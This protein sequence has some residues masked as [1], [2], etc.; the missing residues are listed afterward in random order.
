M[1]RFG[2][3]DPPYYAQSTATDTSFVVAPGSD[4]RIAI[5]DVVISCAADTEFDI[6]D[7]DDTV[8]FPAT[9]QCSIS[10]QAPIEVTANKGL[11]VTKTGSGTS[12]IF[13]GYYIIRD[14]S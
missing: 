12:A 5:T 9:Q 2:W 3:G 14:K 8:L 1:L 11:K 7:G 10:L 13:I 4:K 6:K